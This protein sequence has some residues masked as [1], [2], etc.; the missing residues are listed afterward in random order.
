MSGFAGLRDIPPYNQMGAK[1]AIESPEV[2][3][4]VRQMVATFEQRRDRVLE[5]LG[6]IDGVSCQKPGGAFYLFPNVSGLC[7][8]LGTIFQARLVKELR[9]KGISRV[10]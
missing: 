4:Q 2:R 6:E 7:G 5:L 3:Q 8:R 1:V 9:L 10:E